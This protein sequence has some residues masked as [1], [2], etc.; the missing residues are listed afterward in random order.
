MA[1]ISGMTAEQVKQK[2]AQG[3][4]A[5]RQTLDAKQAEAFKSLP[6]NYQLLAVK[7]WNGVASAKQSIKFKCYDCNGWEEYRERT[8]NCKVTACA[9]WHHRPI[10]DIRVSNENDAS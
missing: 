9:L 3:V 2:T 4:S 8:T 6:A 5:G 1:S 7:V 10:S